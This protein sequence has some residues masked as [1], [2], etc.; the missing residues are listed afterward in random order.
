MNLMIVKS[1]GQT[2]GVKD[3]KA[4]S[5]SN[6]SSKD[7]EK[8]LGFSWKSLRDKVLSGKDM[9]AK[10]A[11]AVKA[12][13]DT[14]KTKEKVYEELLEYLEVEGYPGEEDPDFGGANVNDLVLFA[15][16]PT[17]ANFR[18]R[19]GRNILL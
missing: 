18:R 7:A 15:I 2:E 14:L 16:T 10:S 13:D 3:T 8:R 5:Y 11:Y 6:V 17:L 9:L 12:G 1:Y 19:T 4:T